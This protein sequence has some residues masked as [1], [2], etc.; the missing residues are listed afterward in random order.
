MQAEEH[1]LVCLQRKEANTG[2][3]QTDPEGTLRLGLPIEV[4]I[5]RGKAICLLLNVYHILG[6]IHLALSYFILQI[7]PIRQKSISLI[8]YVLICFLFQIY[9][10]PIQNQQL[11]NMCKA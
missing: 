2:K 6:W 8:G 7:R 9:F 11:S 1:I 4:K 10:N 3:K 5:V